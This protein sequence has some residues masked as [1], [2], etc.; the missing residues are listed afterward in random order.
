MYMYIYTH[1]CNSRGGSFA[2][3]TDMCVVTHTKPTISLSTQT[4]VDVKKK[5]DAHLHKRSYICSKDRHVCSDTHKIDPIIVK[6][7]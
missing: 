1:V 3:K 4:P 6:P 5:K 7:C 2:E